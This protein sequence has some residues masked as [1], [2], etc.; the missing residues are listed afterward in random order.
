MEVMLGTAR[1]GLRGEDE[2]GDDEM[3]S[4]NIER[5][6]EKARLG[7]PLFDKMGKGLEHYGYGFGTNM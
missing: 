6:R 2:Y 4:K 5:Y 7:L 3:R 1:T